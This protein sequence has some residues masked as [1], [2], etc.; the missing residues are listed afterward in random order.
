MRSAIE[1]AG[2]EPE[3]PALA[4]APAK[5]VELIPPGG[6]LWPGCVAGA[7]LGGAV[8][9]GAAIAGVDESAC[10]AVA[11]VAAA[12]V[13]GARRCAVTRGERAERRTCVEAV[14]AE[15]GPGMTGVSGRAGAGRTV[16]RV[17]EAATVARAGAGVVCAE[18]T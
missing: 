10:G 17:G 12:G 2:L 14:G 13:R 18:V 15:V 7:G 8:V 16:A 5:L 3:A 9:D 6:A 1:P 11:V 4:V